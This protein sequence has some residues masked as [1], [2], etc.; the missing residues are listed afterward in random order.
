MAINKINLLFQA[1]QP[2]E[3]KANIQIH[4]INNGI[5]AISGNKINQGVKI[6]DI[7]TGATNQ[8]H[9]IF[10]VTG[11][12]YVSVEAARLF[13]H[14]RGGMIGNLLATPHNGNKPMVSRETAIKSNRPCW[15]DIVNMIEIGT[16]T[17][18]VFSIDTKRRLWLSAQMGIV[19]DNWR[20]FLHDKSVSK[21]ITVSIDQLRRCLQLLEKIYVCG[22]SKNHMSSSLYDYSVIKKQ[23]LSFKEVSKLENK[24]APWRTTDEF[25]LAKFIVQKPLTEEKQC[26]PHLFNQQQMALFE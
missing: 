9:E 1:F 12:E 8:P 3:L 15:M 4:E 10:R 21:N 5:C 24:L 2:P 25:L 13:K 7:V 17:V 6:V 20:V 14:M 19:G 16:P 26:N 22:F 11:T 23:N 18:A